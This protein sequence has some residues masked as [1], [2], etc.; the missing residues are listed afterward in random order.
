M[1]LVCA[2]LVGVN[3]WCAV[4]YMAVGLKVG[5]CNLK[6]GARVLILILPSACRMVLTLEPAATSQMPST[7]HPLYTHSQQPMADAPWPHEQLPVADAPR[8]CCAGVHHHWRGG[9]ADAGA[10][11]G[12]A[13]ARGGGHAWPPEG[14]DREIG[15]IGCRSQGCSFYLLSGLRCMRGRC[16]LQV[17]SYH[18]CCHHCPGQS[19]VLVCTCSHVH[20]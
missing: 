2:A 10:G 7:D 8:Q 9:H 20:D 16:R 12:S 14:A 3:T 15:K 11:T 19:G 13:A 6:L 1:V 18:L 17:P 5:P 4:A